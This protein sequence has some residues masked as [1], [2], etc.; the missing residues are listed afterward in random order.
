MTSVSS[1]TWNCS[2]NVFFVPFSC[3]ADKGEFISKY[4]L[5]LAIAICLFAS[6]QKYV[7]AMCGCPYDY[8]LYHVTLLLLINQNSK[9]ILT[10]FHMTTTGRIPFLLLINFVRQK[11]GHREKHLTTF[12]PKF[13]NE[14]NRVSPL[15]TGPDLTQ[16]RSIDDEWRWR[17]ELEWVS[18]RMNEWIHKRSFPWKQM[19]NFSEEG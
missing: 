4:L 1:K 9:H 13:S 3:I 6:I 17:S 11:L 5:Q 18:E 7:F 14:E 16:H 8:T 19:H 10:L 2:W 12:F 15:V